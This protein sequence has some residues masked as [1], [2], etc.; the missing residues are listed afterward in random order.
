MK[1]QCRYNII[2][3]DNAKEMQ[4]KER[5]S[6]LSSNNLNTITYVTMKRHVI[7]YIW[8]NKQGNGK[9]SVFRTQEVLHNTYMV[10]RKELLLVCVC[11]TCRH[12]KLVKEG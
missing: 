8:D 12:L 2:K 10:N 3:T 6:Q 4:K 9:T 1:I 5:T 11:Q 7:Q